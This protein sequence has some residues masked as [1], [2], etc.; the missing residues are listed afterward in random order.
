MMYPNTT[1]VPN[2]LFD[3]YLRELQTVELKVLLVIIRQTL[4]WT[5]RRAMLGRKEIDWISNSQLQNKT[6][7]SRR[8]ISS[9]IETLVK[10]KL[11]EV[12]D[13]TGNILIDAQKRKG[14]PRLFYRLSVA[15]IS[16]V[17]NAGITSVMQTKSGSAYANFTQDM[18]NKCAALAQKMRITK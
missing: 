3:V 16:P 18:S 7:S 15:L 13:A 1:P 10:K 12:L 14:K 8:A 2:S 4:G 6:C 11:I 17:E 9:A 5:D